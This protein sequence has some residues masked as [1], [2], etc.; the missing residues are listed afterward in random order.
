ME[1]ELQDIEVKFNSITDARQRALGGIYMLTNITTTES[2]AV[3]QV[4]R[5]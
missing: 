3:I 5:L 2:H 4:Y 1:S